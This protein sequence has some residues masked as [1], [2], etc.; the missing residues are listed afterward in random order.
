MDF[1]L[2]EEQEALRKAARDFLSERSTTQLVRKLMASKTGFDEGLWKE[3]SSLG[4]MGTAIS[5]E[6]GGL[7]L[8][9]IEL[10]ILAE[11]TGRAI[12][13]A[14]VRGISLIRCTACGTL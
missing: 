1:G 9:Q 7:G 3:M 12:L 13:P 4:W 11:E 10:A 5:E 6:D 14:P 8:G 2:T